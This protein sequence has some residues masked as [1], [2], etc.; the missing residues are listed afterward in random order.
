M[1]VL[2]SKD[3][4]HRIFKLVTK[5]VTGTTTIEAKEAVTSSLFERLQ[6]KLS[7]PGVL[8]EVT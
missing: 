5:E 8:A 2:C 1:P 4:Y 7:T 3:H 6:H